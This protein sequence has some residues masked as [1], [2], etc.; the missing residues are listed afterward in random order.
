MAVTNQTLEYI[1]ELI[2]ARIDLSCPNIVIIIHNCL[3]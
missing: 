1:L 2:I 3:V